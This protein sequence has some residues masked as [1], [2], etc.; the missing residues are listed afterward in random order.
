MRQPVSH[1]GD[2]RPGNAWF[3]GRELRSQTFH[4]FADLDQADPH[5]VEDEAVTEVA[6]PKVVA[7]GVDRGQDVLDPLAIVATQ[8]GTASASAAAA[9]PGLRS[10]AG[11]ISTRTSSRFS[12]SR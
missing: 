10:A 12:S 7:D 8:R 1:L 9:T 5:C 3:A 11:T 6:P 4:G 2:L